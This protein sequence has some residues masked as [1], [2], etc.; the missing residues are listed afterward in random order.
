MG[1]RRCRGRARRSRRRGQSQVAADGV[2]GLAWRWATE[3]HSPAVSTPGRRSPAV[4]ALGQVS[5]IRSLFVTYTVVIGHIHEVN[6]GQ[7]H[8]HPS[9]AAGAGQSPTYAPYPVAYALRSVRTVPSSKCTHTGGRLVARVPDTSSKASRSG[10]WGQA[11]VWIT[12]I[13]GLI[14]ALTGVVAFFFFGPSA[15]ETPPPG[16]SPG[17]PSLP[18]VLSQEPAVVVPRQ[19]GITFTADG[20]P[21]VDVTP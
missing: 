2:K 16:T 18:R 5:P 20:K 4:E 9:A 1:V 12:A 3:R 8:R 17:P 15:G 13:S 19:S 10:I 14:V 7:D 6:A 11:P 21:R